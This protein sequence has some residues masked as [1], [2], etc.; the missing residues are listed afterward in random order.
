MV[1]ETAKENPLLAALLG[2]I[3]LVYGMIEFSKG[4]TL[5]FFC[6]CGALAL[7]VPCVG[8]MMLIVDRATFAEWHVY[9]GY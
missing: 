7:A 3:F 2:A 8:L 1:I 4:T 9:L 5:R 6:V